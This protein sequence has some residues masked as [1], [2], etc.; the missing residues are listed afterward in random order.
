MARQGAEPSATT[1][2]RQSSSTSRRVCS[3]G[4]SDNLALAVTAEAIGR[5][6]PVL[7]GP[8]LNQP[9]LDHP[10]AQ[11]SLKTLPTWGVTVVPMQDLGEGPRLAPTEELLAAVAPFVKRA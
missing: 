4:I 7:V 11:A 2:T 8:S 1:L 3:N 10:Q 6:T 9:L 5:G